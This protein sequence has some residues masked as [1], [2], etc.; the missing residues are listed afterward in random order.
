M[1]SSLKILPIDSKS[2]KL[3]ANKLIEKKIIP[4]HGYSVAFVGATG[5]GKSTLL[6]N[7]LLR[8]Y[9]DIYDIKNDVYFLSPTAKV[10]DICNQ[11]GIPDKHRIDDD[12]LETVEKLVSYRTQEV[13]NNPNSKT[14]PMLIILDDFTSNRKLQNSKII[15]QLAT[16][17]RHLNLS[18]WL[19][20]HKYK[21]IPRTVRLN[22]MSF[23]IF[24]LNRS[25]VK[26][27][28]DEQGGG[29]LLYNDFED[30]FNYATKEPYTFLSIY[31]KEPYSIRFRKCLQEILRIE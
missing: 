21:A 1:N 18:L 2:V 8:F 20:T 14:K 29:K 31:C 24:S 13:K 4:A 23:Y 19:C 22:I 9:K 17:S 7:L 15:I 5:S 27:L 10:D 6:V 30:M 3:K 28:F 26:Q 16:A 25:E 12:I 11:T